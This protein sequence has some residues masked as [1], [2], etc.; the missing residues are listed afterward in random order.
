MATKMRSRVKVQG[1]DEALKKC[2]DIDAR[3]RKVLGPAVLDGA[4]IVAAEARNRAP[5]SIKNAIIVK[6][7]W[8]KGKSKAFAAAMVENKPEYTKIVKNPGARGSKWKRK[9]VFYPAVVELGH[10]HAPPHPYLRPAIKA[11]RRLVRATVANRIKAA[12]ERG[13]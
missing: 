11:K 3:I 9:T 4:E 1:V 10:P 7:T 13:T 12:I 8:D 2:K 6:K 5:G